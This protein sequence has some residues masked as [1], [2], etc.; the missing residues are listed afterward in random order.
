MQMSDDSEISRRIGVPVS[1]TANRRPV[2]NQMIVHLRFQTAIME[3]LPL[4][5]IPS[6]L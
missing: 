6:V 5:T 1:G 3:H 4:E 2:L